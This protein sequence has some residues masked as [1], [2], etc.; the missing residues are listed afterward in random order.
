MRV[1]GL[2]FIFQVVGIDQLIDH[3]VML[4][5]QEIK[6]L[7]ISP[8]DLFQNKTYILHKL[9][10]E[11]KKRPC[12]SKVSQL[13]S[14]FFHN[15]GLLPALG[16]DVIDQDTGCHGSIQRSDMA[17]HRQSDDEVAFFSDKS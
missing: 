3:L 5:K 14:A 9:I 4:G 1:D 12:L 16:N 11:Q 17:I 13:I 2:I 8:S 15:C 6:S 7:L 10:M